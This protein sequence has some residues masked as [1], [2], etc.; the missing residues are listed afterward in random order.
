MN[1]KELDDVKTFLAQNP[2]AG[3]VIRGSGGA[4]KARMPIA[5]RGKSGGYR[6]ITFYSGADFPL[7]LL[8]INAKSQKDNL[9]QAETNELRFILAS[10]VRHCREATS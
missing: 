6:I 8:D 10:I 1:D 2:T 3:T 5:G 7:F 9:T 4:R